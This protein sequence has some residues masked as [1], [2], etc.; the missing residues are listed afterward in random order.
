MIKPLNRASLAKGIVLTA[1]ILL[2][3]AAGCKKKNS[4]F[5]LSPNLNVADDIVFTER[6]LFHT[7][8][9]LLKAN[10]DTTIMHQGV[11]T[12]D[13]AIITYNSVVRRF[14]VF[15]QNKYCADTV[16][17]NGNIIINLN[18][19][20]FSAGTVAI[21]TFRKYSED[22]RQFIGKD[23][24]V[25]HGLSSGSIT[26]YVSFINGLL[27]TKDS[28]LSTR[29]NS[30]L[31]YSIPPI[32]KILPDSLM[33]LT[34]SGSA[35]GLSSSNYGFSFQISEPLV[36]NLYCPWIRSGVMQL[37]TPSLQVTTGTIE[38]V[39]QAKCNDRVTYNFEGSIF[40]WWIN[41]KKLSF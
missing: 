29:W 26:T 5:D 33:P 30:N 22:S 39:N 18:G 11:G 35:I 16:L 36:D 7:F 32:L 6:G 20:F 15:Y 21:I 3:A 31:E 24:L 37:S 17:R 28:L 14:S 38:Y 27:I 40:E 9:L 13:K 4:S 34:I 19:D 12:I 8:G 1:I 23:S 10:L 2:T 41:R 25:N